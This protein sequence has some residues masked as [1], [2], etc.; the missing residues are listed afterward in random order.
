MIASES[1]LLPEPFGPM[2]ACASPLRTT[3][4]IPLRISLP[5]TETWRSLISSVDTDASPPC[6]RLRRDGHVLLL[7]LAG[8]LGERHA[9]ERGRDGR[10]E[11]QP[12]KP[13]AAVLLADAGED[14]VAFRSTVL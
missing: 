14:P 1:V 6:S 4:S 3:R 9:V 13:S 12:D 2:I 8:Q 7:R 5:S 11:L 10:L